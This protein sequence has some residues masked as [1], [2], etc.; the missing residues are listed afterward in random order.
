MSLTGGYT[1]INAIIEEVRGNGFQDF[2][3]DEVKEWVWKILGYIAAPDLYVSKF[4]ELKIENFKA[5]LPEDFKEIMD[6]GIRMKGSRIALRKSTDIFYGDGMNVSENSIRTVAGRSVVFV[7]DE[8]NEDNATEYISELST[9]YPE[10]TLVFT[11]NDYVITTGFRSG[12]IE[13]MYKGYNT[14][15]FNN[16]L[17]P[18]HPKVIRAVVSFV[19]E[20][21]A[22]R[23]M[24]RDELAVGKYDKINQ[25]YMFNVGAA[26]SAARIP[27]PSEM[28]NYSRRASTIQSNFT[29]FKNGFK[30]GI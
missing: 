4:C 15:E 14:D 21:I 7:D 30:R 18:D 3:P 16:P 17:I 22:F 9:V 28:E 25:D 27:E 13:I 24:L 5:L 26:I 29:G 1:G 8:P 2:Y 11:I 23:M 19:M 10:E 12:T 20:R 6:G